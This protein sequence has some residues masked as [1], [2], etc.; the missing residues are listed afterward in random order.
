LP[1]VVVV[2]AENLTSGGMG[3]VAL[4][5]LVHAHWGAGGYGALLACMAAGAVIGTLAAARTGRLPNPGMLA[6]W[7]I[8]TVGCATSLAVTGVL[9]RH[10]GTTPFFP[11]AGIFLVLSVKAVSLDGGRE[12]S[13]MEGR[14]RAGALPGR[15]L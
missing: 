3:E 8:I 13:T 7:A 1:I 4:L 2:I 12:A 6:S 5:A 14:R 11:I 9:V 15:W 10:V